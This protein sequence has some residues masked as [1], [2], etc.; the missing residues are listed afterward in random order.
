M[1]I[2]P[3]KDMAQKPTK[4]K[5][6]LLRWTEFC[7][8]YR[9]GDSVTLMSDSSSHTLDISTS[10]FTKG[11]KL[12][13]ITVG[14]GSQTGQAFVGSIAMLRLFDREL[15]TQEKQDL[16]TCR[17][18]SH[19]TVNFT[20]EKKPSGNGFETVLK[21]N[22]VKRSSICGILTPVDY[23]ISALRHGSYEET[24]S[25]CEIFG[26]RL[27]SMNKDFVE[28]ITDR[29][30]FSQKDEEANQN[31]IY[32]EN[33]AMNNGCNSL[34][35]DQTVHDSYSY[36]NVTIPCS[37]QVKYA[38]CIIPASYE[39]KSF[40]GDIENPVLM[41]RP[42]RQIVVFYNTHFAVLRYKKC[43]DDMFMCWEYWDEAM[44]LYYYVST[45]WK[46]FLVGRRDWKHDKHRKN[47]TDGVPPD[48]TVTMSVCDSSSFTC[49]TGHCVPLEKRCNFEA[50]CEDSSDESTT[51]DRH[52]PLPSSY[53]KA[54]CPVNHPVIDMEVKNLGVQ[55]ILMNHNEVRVSLDVTL[56]WHDPRVT[57]I[58]LI[59]EGKQTLSIE[60][61]EKLWAPAVYLPNGIYEDNLRT[62][63]RKEILE[64]LSAT[65]EKQIQIGLF[66]SSEGIVHVFETF[67][68]S[69]ISALADFLVSIYLDKYIKGRQ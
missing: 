6:D 46:D 3:S 48:A 58:N 9:A 68:F 57:F 14:I 5:F 16:N 66:D 44:E 39:L 8:T 40:R 12:Q 19:G 63:K 38:V 41:P 69:R 27:P 33:D 52:K 37:E 13:N 22:L 26:A 15:T 21:Q 55:E 18:S 64:D 45:D 10:N 32:V 29:F 43:L 23:Q 50:D 28:D 60:F 51:C 31:F 59:Q 4:L 53:W 1:S 35:V 2:K 62:N 30:F 42:S 17:E 61:L 7:L 20:A 56:S 65:R 67:V 36:D 24:K 47:T 11:K 54:Y 49:N 34:L 25:F